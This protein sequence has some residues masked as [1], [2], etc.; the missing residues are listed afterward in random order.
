VEEVERAPDERESEHGISNVS[1][2]RPVS[3]ESQSAFSS[4]TDTQSKTVYFIG[5]SGARLAGR[6]DVPAERPRSVFLF[7][8]AFGSSKDL[9]SMRRIAQMLAQRECAVLRFDFTGVGQSEG[10]FPKTDFT[11]NVADVHAAASFLK[12]ELQPPQFLF[13][14]SLGGL[15]VLRA[16]REMAECKGVATY[17]TPTSPGHVREALLRRAPQ[18]LEQGEAVVETMGKRVTVSAS[19]LEDFARHDGLIDATEL[20]RG[21]KRLL[22]AQSLSDPY[23]SP[24][25]GRALFAAAGPHGTLFEWSDADH[26]L[27]ERES[28]AGLLAAAL[29]GWAGIK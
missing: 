24:D 14:H 13:G 26:L 23:L 19:M 4:G 15:A 5:G 20:A 8:H 21:G 28:D 12:H 11:T 6:L 22:V 29:V 3:E 18:I 7:A 2:T 17:A 16:A 9:R 1:V 10:D 27:L 25:H